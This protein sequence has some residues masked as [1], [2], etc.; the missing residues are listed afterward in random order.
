MNDMK[1]L[2]A[3]NTAIWIRDNWNKIPENEL[4]KFIEQISEY[5]VFSNRQI[6]RLFNNRVNHSRVREYTKK[7]QKTG[8]SLS[9]ESLEDI[10][11]ALFSRFKNKIDYEAIS[12]AIQ[13]GTS[14]NMITR[15]SGVS[16]SSISRRLKNDNN[17]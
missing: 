4:Q 3:I 9:P 7:T 17:K 1:R 13:K 16:Q 6:A 10:R 15:L 12:R 2:E 11:E 8:G 5:D 14:Q